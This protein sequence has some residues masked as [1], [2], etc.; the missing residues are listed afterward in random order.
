MTMRD[1]GALIETVRV[2]DG[3]APLWYLHLRRLV[4]SCI[5]L[6]I[7]FPGTLETPEGGIDRVHR[8]EVG[9]RNVAVSTRL[10]GSSA[11]VTLVTART[12]HRPY[13]HKT[14]RRDTFAAAA[15]EATAAG[16]DDALLLDPAGRVAEA[17]I[18]SVLWW[19]GDRL[20]APPLTSGVLP[21]VARARL[22]EVAT[23]HEV[24]A[25][26]SALAGRSLIV[27][28]AVRGPVPVATLDGDPVPEHPGT[29]RLQAA[30]W[31]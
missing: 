16:A 25:P 11:P 29:A 22:A 26:R 12:P 30:F 13:R 24:A 2:R 14:T 18:W 27:A 31:P 19:D 28:N 3:A 21:G 15:G 17:T 9:P 10:V 8:L 1:A 20:C 5:A 6:G 7:P 4:E 23:L